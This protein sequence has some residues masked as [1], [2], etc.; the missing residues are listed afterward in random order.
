M[1]PLTNIHTLH[2][3]PHGKLLDLVKNT[4]RLNRLFRGLKSWLED[5]KSEQDLHQ[6]FWF[7]ND[8]SQKWCQ[9]IYDSISVLNVRSITFWQ[10]IKLHALS[11]TMTGLR[12][13]AGITPHQCEAL[14]S[15]H[16]QAY[17]NGC[18]FVPQLTSYHCLDDWS[19]SWSI[20]RNSSK[21]MG[22]G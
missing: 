12:D 20:S 3:S 4:L 15:A 9:H 7:T 5:N 17:M 13:A 11:V 16:C 21:S 2:T 19:L 14:A 22:L 1:L 8:E 6:Y 18:D 10:K